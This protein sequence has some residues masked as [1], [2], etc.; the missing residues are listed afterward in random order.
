MSWSQF[1]ISGT[2]SYQRSQRPTANVI[3]NLNVFLTLKLVTR[4]K[5][6][7]PVYEAWDQITRIDIDDIST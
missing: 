3:T 4:Y 7:D 6:K 1:T 5:H 2:L